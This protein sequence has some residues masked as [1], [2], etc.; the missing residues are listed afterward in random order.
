MPDYRKVGCDAYRELLSA[1]LDGEATPSEI[2]VS[3][4]HLAACEECRRWYERAAS[5]SRLVRI[6]PVTQGPDVVDAVLAAAPG[7]GRARLARVLWSLLGVLGAAQVA[8]G[9]LQAASAAAAEY[10]GHPA[11]VMSGASV[12]HLWHESAAWNVAVGAAFLWVSG[13]RSR[14]AGI[15]PILTAF[16]IGLGLLSA[17]DIVN[18]HVG[19]TRIASHGLLVAGYLIVLALSRPSFA[20]GSPPGGRVTGGD[21]ASEIDA[22]AP[23]PT[24]RY[25][26]AA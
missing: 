5:V 9:V 21:D 1:R 19:A 25:R 4:T 7:R 6:G 16:V 13:R 22:S 17:G 2:A 18:G 26:D 20:F 14:P 12:G 11:G 15:I 8:L 10:G 3:D 24:V 23:L